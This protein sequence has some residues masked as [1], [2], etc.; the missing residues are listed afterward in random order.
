MSEKRA[1]VRMDTCGSV[2]IDLG[3]SSP[4]L[5]CADLKD[6]G[7]G[8][9]CMHT[10]EALDLGSNI[11]FQLM[12]QS[13]YQAIIGKGAIKYSLHL[14]PGRAYCF[15]AGV[16]FIDINKDMIMHIL[17]KPRIKASHQTVN[18]SR[19]SAIDYIPF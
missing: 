3:K 7:Y 12:I 15:K 14:G 5:I 10:S 8:G 11:D 6:I 2:K 18:R 1:F 9:F 16:E 19:V 13:S 17:N 4:Q